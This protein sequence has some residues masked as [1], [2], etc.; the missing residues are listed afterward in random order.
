MDFAQLPKH[1]YLFGSFKEPGKGNRGS[2]QLLPS[3]IP[4]PTKTKV[5]T[6]TRLWEKI[7]KKELKID[8]T[9]YSMK[10]YGANKKLEA[11]I[12]IDAIQNV[13]GHST[14]EMTHIYLTNLNEVSR[15]EISE[16]T[17]KL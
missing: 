3:L 14:K 12:S 4:A 17:P 1:Y 6:T 15:K 16:K 5:D 7:V 11:G 9:M 2:N 8:V 13:H 10:K